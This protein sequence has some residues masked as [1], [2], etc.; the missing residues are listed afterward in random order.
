VV[1]TVSAREAVEA[2]QL[3]VTATPARGPV[4]LDEWVGPGTHIT[5]VGSDLPDKQELEPSL[6][7]RSTVVADHLAQCLTQ[8]EIHHAVAAGTITAADVHAELGE[9]A[10]GSKRGRTSKDE[11]T[12]ADLTGVGVLDAAM[13]NYVVAAA[14]DADVGSEVAV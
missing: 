7:A 4:V 14:L 6:L 13:A 10:A 2:S 5:A 1:P 9:I 8:G 11:V 12:V 3:V